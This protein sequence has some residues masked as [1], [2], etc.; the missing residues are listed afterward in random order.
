MIQVVQLAALH[1]LF[2]ALGFY[3]S[4]KQQRFGENDE[5][6]Q[7]EDVGTYVPASN[8]TSFQHL[9]AENVSGP[10]ERLNVE[11]S[12]PSGTY[13]NTSTWTICFHR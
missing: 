5:Q 9:D 4:V 1:T 2:A 11:R 6:Q 7:Q 12:G 3:S 10:S 8:G 13:I